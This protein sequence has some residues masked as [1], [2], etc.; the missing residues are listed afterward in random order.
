MS[1]LA[2]AVHSVHIYNEQSAL[3]SRLCG[4]VASSLRVGDSVLIV[5][6]LDTRN[7]LTDELRKTEVDVRVHA[8]QGR[9][10]MVDASEALSTFIIDDMP[11]AGLFTISIGQMLADSRKR[12]RSRQQGLTVFGEMVAVLWDQ[13]NKEAALRL[14]ALWNA[15]LHDRT[16]HLHCA[17][18]RW[19]FKNDS[20]ITAV[21]SAHS[22]VLQDLIHAGRQPVASDYAA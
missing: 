8:R 6:T 12:A 14:E 2:P 15:A 18:P 9:F 16:F 21:C 22:H 5:A 4:V 1:A 19:L 7:Q 11:D 3:I 17:Y 20:D 10:T 13:G